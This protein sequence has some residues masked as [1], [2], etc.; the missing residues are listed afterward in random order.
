MWILFVISLF[1]ILGLFFGWQT[2]LVDNQ[3]FILDSLVLTIGWFAF[4]LFVTGALLYYTETDKVRLE[5]NL[6]V[7]KSGKVNMPDELTPH[8]E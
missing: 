1:F 6:P 7:K 3:F 2:F 5:Y 8:E 4:W